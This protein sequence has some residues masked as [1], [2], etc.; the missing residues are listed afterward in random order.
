MKD[1]TFVFIQD[2]KEKGHTA[3]S[4]RSKRTH[5]GK[6]GRVKF[7]SDYMT[8]K[9][10]QKM[11]GEVKSYRLNAPMAWEEFKTLP[12][13]M[14]VTYIKLLREKFDVPDS[15]IGKMMGADKDKVSRFFKALGLRRDS[16]RGNHKWDS[17]G[18]LAFVNG[19]P[20]P[21]AVPVEE[22]PEAVELT[23]DETPENVRQVA[24]LEE[25]FE[26]VRVSEVKVL[27]VR[28]ENA[29]A[30]PDCGSM[31]FEGRVEDILNS[32]SVLLGGQMSTS[33]LH[34]MSFEKKGDIICAI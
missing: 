7:P 18:W 8:K 11:N 13:D 6:G 2:V 29:K 16:R 17:E 23:A 3:R 28:Q 10:I 30:I 9:E 24:S 31:T 25:I 22:A 21:A 5:N 34:G 33:V 1:E 27:P 15:E 20:V 26:P 12:D 4:A 14:K 19:I 32:V